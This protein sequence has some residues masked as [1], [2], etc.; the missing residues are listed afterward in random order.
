M[1]HD[2]PLDS[3][4]TTE[5]LPD[6]K[7]RAIALAKQGYRVFPL[8]VLGRKPAIENFPERAS[9]DPEV[10]A[11]M[12]SSVVGDRENFNIGIATGHGLLAVDY[13]C[14]HGK[15]GLD[16]REAFERMGLPQTVRVRT[17]SGGEH[18]YLRTPDNVTI[19]QTVGT[20]G[21]GVDTRATHG[22]V[23]AP[24]SVLDGDGTPAAPWTGRRS[25]EW[26]QDPGESGF[27]RVEPCPEW[28]MSKVAEQTWRKN[29]HA[30]TKGGQAIASPLD[31][32]AAIARAKDYLIHTAPYAVEGDHGDHTTLRVAMRLKDFGLSA[33][34]VL[35]LMLAE[36]NEFKASPPWSP[37][38]LEL[39]VR[40]AFRY[41]Q[42]PVG[43]DHPVAT[44]GDP[45]VYSHMSA[46]TADRT[47]ASAIAGMGPPQDDAVPDW[48][49]PDNRASIDPLQVSGHTFLFDGHYTKGT[50]S[51]LVAPSGGGKTQLLLQMAAALATG[52]DDI[53]GLTPVNPNGARVWIWNQEE[54]TVEL[55]RRVAAIKTA[56]KIPP[57]KL[58]GRFL[59]KSGVDKPFKLVVPTSDGTV[60]PCKHVDWA[61]QVI[62]ER[63]IDVLILDPFIE[64]HSLNENDNAVMA[65]VMALVRRI[66][67]EGTCAVVL[68][69]HDRKPGAASS[70]GHAGNAHAARGAS[71]MLGV[72]R[73][74]G[75]LY[76]MSKADADRYG[77]PEDDVWRYV[78]F[79]MAKSNVS[80]VTGRA[81]W[82]ERRGQCYRDMKCGHEKADY[83]DGNGQGWTGNPDFEI[84][85][86]KPVTLAFNVEVKTSPTSIPIPEIETRNWI[87]KAIKRF[88]SEHEIDANKKLDT[89]DILA[90]LRDPEFYTEKR[91]TLRQW[92]RRLED[93]LVGGQPI[94]SEDLSATARGG[95]EISVPGH[96]LLQFER[97]RRGKGTRLRLIDD[98]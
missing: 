3:S 4:M 51:M 12:W 57:E 83:W 1:A 75:T 55:D 24:G 17:P 9:N 81:V 10:V 67:T 97:L 13:D 19:G 79:D 7:K 41:G 26:L 93:A 46:G 36:W 82:I 68:G 88:R 70:D 11:K 5:G 28:F 2:G 94:N 6:M 69:H 73:E 64:F 84:G 32:Q 50:V 20:I 35:E 95:R 43:I 27:D 34:V 14:K 52:R 74:V 53:C 91:V 96:G 29:G 45:N 44:F 47:A 21:P 30:A 49:Q 71:S 87:C 76:Q 61:I 23:I 72:T 25:Y 58:V 62:R 92:S 59:T 90:L 98:D 89:R 63:A 31:D 16:S 80:A 48:F 66:A 65:G 42:N 78:R 38:D 33:P 77:V 56:F 15:K 18:L 8:D 22:Y 37:D 85:V 39:K 54:G 86:L 60:R 40:N